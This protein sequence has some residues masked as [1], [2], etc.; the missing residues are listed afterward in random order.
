MTTLTVTDR[1]LPART[2]VIG[3]TT[4]CLQNKLLAAASRIRCDFTEGMLI[5]SGEVR[6]YRHKQLA[7]ECTRDVAGVEQI[8]NRLQ[9]VR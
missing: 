7:Q 6:T 4:S 3:E 1:P 2:R 8:V 9:V 5:L